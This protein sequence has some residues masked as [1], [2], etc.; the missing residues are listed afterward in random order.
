MN[1]QV[2]IFCLGLIASAGFIIANYVL[3]RERILIFQG[4]GM[5]GVGSMFAVRA[6]YENNPVFWGP[7]VINSIFI[8]RNVILYFRDKA[9][10]QFGGVGDVGRVKLGWIFM[11]VIVGAYFVVTPIPVWTDNL[12]L[13]IF[14]LPLAAAVTNVLAIAQKHILAL[15]WF[16]LVS[17]ACW[18]VFDIT[19]SAWSTL[20]GD[21]F[22]VAATAVA[23]FRLHRKHVE[24]GEVL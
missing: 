6:V 20:I 1:M 19:V 8:I 22:G 4:V 3:S 5:L 17:V 11:I 10:L 12:S 23:L 21:L 15:K 13:A 18:A 24:T 7:V 16:I 9:T 14:F 2:L